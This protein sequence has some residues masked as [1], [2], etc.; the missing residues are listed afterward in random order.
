L[1]IAELDAFVSPRDA[2]VGYDRAMYHQRHLAF[3]ERCGSQKSEISGGIVCIA[4]KLFVQELFVQDWY[5][6]AGVD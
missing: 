2:S 3:K 1:K 4:Q 6:S 5:K